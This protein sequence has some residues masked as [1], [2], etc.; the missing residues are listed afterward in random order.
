MAISS[1]PVQQ[2]TGTGSVS[3]TSYTIT[4]GA[5]MTA[6]NVVVLVHT[7]TATDANSAISSISATNVTWHS[8]VV[9]ATNTRAEIWYGEIAAGAGT[10]ITVNLA[11]AASAVDHANASEWSGLATSSELGVTGT[12]SATSANPTTASITPTAGRNTLIIACTRRGGTFSSGPDT[13]GFTALTSPTTSDQYGYLVVASASGSYSTSWTWTTSLAWGASIASFYAP[14]ATGKLFLPTNL[15][16]LGSG[17][18][19][20]GNPLN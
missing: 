7:V 3:A 15:S 1:V 6:G 14:L 13:G 10:V 11:G 20:F 17:G 5:N 9:F 2:A 16:G 19:F 12:N 8:A 18:P 4:M